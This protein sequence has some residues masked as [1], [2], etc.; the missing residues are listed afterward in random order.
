MMCVMT[1]SAERGI[2]QETI[3]SV[4]KNTQLHETSLTPTAGTG[5]ARFRGKICI[6]QLPVSC[7]SK[8]SIGERCC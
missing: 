8:E 7:E 3:E 5:K 4:Q 1:C 6:T 2:H